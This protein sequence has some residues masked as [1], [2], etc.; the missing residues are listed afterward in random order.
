[1]KNILELFN[2]TT[3][4]ELE[5]DQKMDRQTE[6]IDMSGNL[7][8]KAGTSESGPDTGLLTATETNEVAGSENVEGEGS[9]PENVEAEQRM[10]Q[11]DREKIL[12]DVLSDRNIKAV[13]SPFRTFSDDGQEF[14]GS[15]TYVDLRKVIQKYQNGEITDRMLKILEIIIRHKNITTRQIWQMYML[16]YRRYIKMKNLKKTLNHMVEDGLVG[17]F[18][19]V[20]TTGQSNYYIYAPEYNGVRLYSAIRGEN[21]EWKKTDTVQKPYNVKRCLAANQFLIAFLKNYEMTYKLQKRL[22]WADANGEGKGGVR[23]SLELTF[24]QGNADGLESIVFLVE[25]I[26][27]YQGWEEQFKNKLIRYAGYL[28]SVED[29]Q[30]L[31]KYFIVVCAESEEH[32]G[33]AITCFYE[34]V[35]VQRIHPLKDS[36]FY[37]I[38]DIDLLDGNVEKDL[39]HNLQGMVYDFDMKKWTQNHPYFSLKKRDWNNFSFEEDVICNN[40]KEKSLQEPVR[41]ESGENGKEEIAKRIYRAIF[42][43]GYRFPVNITIVAPYLKWKGIDYRELGYRKLK[44]MFDG[45]LQYYEQKYKSPT[46][47]MISPTEELK[48]L[49]GVSLVEEKDSSGM[50][51]MGERNPEYGEERLES[52]PYSQTLEKHGKAVDMEFNMIED[53]V[54]NGM[55]GRKKWNVQFRS[56]VFC[57][58]WDMTAAIL[59]KV[60]CIYDFTTDGWYNIIAY[61]YQ[62]AKRMRKI[63]TNERY[64]YFDTGIYSAF[65]ESVYLLAEK[66]TKV[67][68]KWVLVGVA[69]KNSKKVGQI[70]K[71]EFG[72]P[73]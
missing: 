39:L 35:H 9:L 47:L 48:R 40:E 58:N 25:V 16:E 7:S 71:K 70:I 8:E 51:D 14:G 62:N 54:I 1:M 49:V 37:F 45:L 2:R 17:Q 50:E 52:Q 11:E 72:M 46:E 24:R 55:A 59:N 27:T 26:R 56:E 53:Y 22:A 18:R 67:Y 65:H 68:P 63:R 42:E 13:E 69:T 29:T 41:D 23:P 34:V 28:K 33:K 44:Q 15:A 32:L 12:A 57:R 6:D 73:D 36:L 10:S 43:G 61:S 19:I 31:K 66:N 5:D 4:K 3:V 64:L 38:T 60:T 21:V 30:D 20:S